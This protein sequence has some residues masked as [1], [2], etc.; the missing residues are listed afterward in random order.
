MAKKGLFFWVPLWFL[1]STMARAQQSLP[2]ETDLHAAYCIEITK[3]GIGLYETALAPLVKDPSNAQTAK[4]VQA[5]LD[6]SK[7]TLRR[8]QLYLAPRAVYLDALSLLGAQHAAKDDWGRIKVASESCGE[9]ANAPDL[10]KCNNECATR[11]M[12]DLP[13]VQQKIQTCQNLSWLPF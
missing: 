8:L 11:M 12:P 3:I 4:S 5:A 6:G 10:F 1:V 2:S 9:C 13:S 7:A